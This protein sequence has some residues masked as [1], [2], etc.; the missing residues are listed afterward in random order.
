MTAF[1][2]QLAV[3]TTTTCDQTPTA[4]TISTTSSD[5]VISAGSFQTITSAGLFTAGPFPDY[6]KAG[7]Y[8]VSVISV[9]LNGVA[10]TLAN[11]KITNTAA[12]PNSFEFTVVNPCATAA[13]TA[14]T[15]A[16][17]TVDVF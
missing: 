17:I 1:T 6:L 9:T 12:S 4:W 10:Y 8:N 16:P 3:D 2:Y 5:N 11:S 14:S 13:V 7:T 15:V